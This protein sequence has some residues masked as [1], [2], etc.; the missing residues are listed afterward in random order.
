MNTITWNATGGV[1]YVSIE[2]SLDGT[3]WITIASRLEASLG[4]FNWYIQPTTTQLSAQTEVSKAVIFFS[5]KLSYDGQMLY[6]G[7]LYLPLMGYSF[8]SIFS[9]ILY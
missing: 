7:L 6:V 4:S 8:S 3:N 1:D 2:H 9:A 5:V